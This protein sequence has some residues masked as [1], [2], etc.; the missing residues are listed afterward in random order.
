[1]NPQEVF[2][3]NH[4]KTEHQHHGGTIYFK[5]ENKKTYIL[6]DNGFTLSIYNQVF[7]QDQDIIQFI[8]N[9]K[10]V[11]YIKLPLEFIDS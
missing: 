4:W 1:M 2:N 8:E 3:L 9:N 5:T 6:E 10:P 11:E 7:N